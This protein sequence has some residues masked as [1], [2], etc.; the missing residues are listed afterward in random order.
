M[1]YAC[2]TKNAQDIIDA[3]NGYTGTSLIHTETAFIVWLW[4]NPSQADLE[5]AQ[6]IAMVAIHIA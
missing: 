3:M 2:V 6:L 4:A 1:T 5:N